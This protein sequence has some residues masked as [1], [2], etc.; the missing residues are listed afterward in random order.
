[1]IKK[2]G[3]IIYEEWKEGK[4][5][6]QFEK[7]KGTTGLKNDNIDYTQF[8]TEAFEKYLETKTKQQLE[9]KSNPLKTKYFTLEFAKM[10]KS[11]NPENYY[12]SVRL[13][14]NTN[15]IVMEKPDLNQW[16]VEDVMNF[17]RKLGFEHYNNKVNEHEINGFKLIHLDI[18]KLSELI[19]I[20]DVNERQSLNKSLSI[21]KKLVQ[22]DNLKSFKSIKLNSNIEIEKKAKESFK[23][24]NKNIILIE[25]E[26]KNDDYISDPE[27][28]LEE[29]AMK[30]DAVLDNNG[31]EIDSESVKES[32]LEEEKNKE[33]IHNL[34]IQEITSPCM[35]YVFILS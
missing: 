29:K 8:N 2:D 19:G 1:M 30:A 28:E 34:A 7:L 11:K 26:N 3:S 27:I 5:I 14:H 20:T 9:L 4:S 32:K 18:D 10:L 15:N 33:M 12:D 16:N 21:L 31:E 22:T 25:E 13:M 6:R 35:I 17:F 24:K 23:T